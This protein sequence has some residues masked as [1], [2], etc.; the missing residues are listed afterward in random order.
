MESGYEI[1]IHK[2]VKAEKLTSKQEII[3]QLLRDCFVHLHANK[4]IFMIYLD[5]IANHKAYDTLA[6]ILAS[7]CSHS[8]P[9]RSLLPPR[10][11]PCSS[12][13]SV[14]YHTLT[15]L[16]N[17]LHLYA[18]LKRT[19]PLFS[20]NPRATYLGMGRISA[21]TFP[22]ARCPCSRLTSTTL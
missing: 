11:V 19:L 5:D 13:G 12:G 8:V 14:S 10:Q 6:L 2:I 4:Y 22:L 15:I 1:Q 7:L 16:P 9:L 18:N 20:H 17:N 3:G 21:T